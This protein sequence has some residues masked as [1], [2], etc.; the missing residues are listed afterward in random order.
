[1]IWIYMSV[2]SSFVKFIR[3]PGAAP[4]PHWSPGCCVPAACSY[5][6]VVCTVVMATQR[7]SA[8]ASAR[9]LRQTAREIGGQI[10]THNSYLKINGNKR[11]Y[12]SVLIHNNEF[13][14]SYKIYTLFR[15]TQHIYLFIYFMYWIVCK[16]GYI[17][18]HLLLSCFWNGGGGEH[19]RL[20]LTS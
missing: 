6:Y 18:K 20:D 7:D 8:T 16:V 10:T 2:W 12:F 3:N 11:N 5:Y 17:C 1:M 14:G 4:C 9:P 15:P 19:L 13:Y